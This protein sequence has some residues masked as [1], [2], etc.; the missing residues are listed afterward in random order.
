MDALKSTYVIL[1]VQCKMKMQISLFKTYYKSQNNK[2]PLCQTQS[3]VQ[4]YRPHVLET[5][6][7]CT[8]IRGP[9]P[10]GGPAH[11]KTVRAAD[12]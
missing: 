7:G 4:L 9:D 11:R 3:P 5:S 10:R 12:Q 2:R 8:L 6:P 1:R